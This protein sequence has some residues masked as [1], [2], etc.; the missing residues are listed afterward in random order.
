MTE[1]YDSEERSRMDKTRTDI[2]A[3]VEPQVA[4]S[5]ES[6]DNRPLVVELSEEDIPGACLSEPLES[7]NVQ[8]LKWWLLC[9]GITAPT[10]WKKS[11]LINR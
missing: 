4:E 9:R 5:M 6:T 1:Q 3:L 8:A 7:H 2:G 10:A 11:N